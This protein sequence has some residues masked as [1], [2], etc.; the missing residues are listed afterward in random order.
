M[1]M[2]GKFTLYRTLYSEKINF[3]VLPGSVMWLSEM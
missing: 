3:L 1:C 2:H